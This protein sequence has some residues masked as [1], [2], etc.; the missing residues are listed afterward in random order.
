MGKMHKRGTI[1]YYREQKKKWLDI[2]Q[3]LSTKNEELLDRVNRAERQ[4]KKIRET[5]SELYTENCWHC[6]DGICSKCNAF[7]KA[8]ADD[9]D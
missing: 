1:P 2:S 9:N 6:A 3:M 8:L 5:A 7:R 4:L